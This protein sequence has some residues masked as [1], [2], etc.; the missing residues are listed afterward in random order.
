MKNLRSI[1]LL[2]CLIP[3]VSCEDWTGINMDFSDPQEVLPILDALPQDLVDAFGV[4]YINFGPTPPNLSDFSFKVE[5]LNYVSSKRYLFGPTDDDE[6]ILSTTNPPT[7]DATIYYH[8]FMDQTERLSKHKLKTVD[9][10][11]NIFLRSNDT[12]YIIGHDSL[13][14]AYYTET[15][16]DP[17][18]GN[19]SN[20]IIVSGTVVLDKNTDEFIGIR[21]YR[22]GKKIKSYDHRPEV[23]S[24]APGTIEI[25]KH[26]ELSLKHIWDTIP[27][28]GN[29]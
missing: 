8:H 6:Y 16:P 5:G 15:I 10:S 3:F 18:S 4:E 2:L 17:Q 13:F 14:T 28:S 9:A 20:H 21:N 11:Q 27:T 29:H 1:I 7:Y 25:K 22:I 23:P 12:V 26:D 19:P 24:Y